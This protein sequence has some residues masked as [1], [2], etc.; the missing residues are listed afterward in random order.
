MKTIH[1]P[2]AKNISNDNGKQ[3]LTAF[4]VHMSIRRHQRPGGQ[5]PLIITK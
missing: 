3:T 4:T 1:R 5:S 2:A